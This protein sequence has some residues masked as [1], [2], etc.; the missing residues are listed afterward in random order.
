[1]PASQAFSISVLAGLL[2]AW[3]SSGVLEAQIVEARLASEPIVSVG[4][5]DTEPLFEV[6][7]VVLTESGF[8][9]GEES[10]QL[11]YYSRSGALTKAGG[12][13]GDGPARFR[14]LAWLRSY[15]DTIV[16]YDPLLRRLSRFTADG[17]YHRAVHLDRHGPFPAVHAV[18]LFADGT[19]LA[20]VG[21]TSARPTEPSTRRA[22]LTLVRYSAS[23]QVVGPIGSFL[24]DEK[25]AEPFGRTGQLSSPL[26]FG[27]Q[28][29]V[30]VNTDRYFVIDGAGPEIQIFGPDGGL[31][32][33]VVPDPAPSSA[34]VS[35]ADVA[36]MRDRLMAET[37]GGDDAMAA[38]DRMAFRSALPAYG[39]VGW[40]PGGTMVVA[41][42]R[43]W[44]MHASGPVESRT[45]W[46]VFDRQGEQVLHLVSDEPLELLDVRGDIAAV[47]RTDVLGVEIVE[48]RRIQR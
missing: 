12:G 8:V 38:F 4:T 35:D 40:Y 31:I 19:L 26:P 45:T 21:G 9:I 1:M 30:G 11:G 14:R 6:V 20:Y 3:G 25:H 33:T 32:R 23:G 16:A 2:I 43:I 22:E 18:G 37:R 7:G 41:D 24:G 27:I 13:S 48:L 5:G 17:L 46:S 15:G 34:A 42:D 47:L 44:V 10:G 29:A 39:R 28:S 36:A